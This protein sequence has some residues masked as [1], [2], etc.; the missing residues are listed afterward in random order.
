MN[1]IKNLLLIS[2]VLMGSFSFADLNTDLAMA[3]LA[4]ASCKCDLKMEPV[5]YSVPRPIGCYIT[6]PAMAG[7]ACRCTARAWDCTSINTSCLNPDSAACKNP[8][9]DQASCEQGQGNCKGY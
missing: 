7:F 6:K 9:T 3:K 1:R 5:A 4:E 8:S 2:S